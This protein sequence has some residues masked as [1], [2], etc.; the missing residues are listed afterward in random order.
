MKALI[1]FLNSENGSSAINYCILSS[2]MT[3]AIT[4]PLHEVGGHLS[5]L[6]L[7]VAKALAVH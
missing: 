4:K 3:A 2:V 6:F 1:E 5:L 7:T